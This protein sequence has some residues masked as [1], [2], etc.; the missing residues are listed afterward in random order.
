MTSSVT[1]ANVGKVYRMYATRWARLAEWLV[2]FGKP[3]HEPKWV[4]RGVDCTIAAGEAVGIV[5]VNGAGKSTLLKIIAGTT[6]PSEGVARVEGRVAALLELGIGF[7]PEFTGRQNVLMAGQLLGLSTD[8]VRAAMPAIEQFADIGDYVD[9][10]VRIYS[11][12]M[13][14][15]LAFSV[16]TAVQPDVLIVDEALAVGDAAFQRKCFRRIEE[17][18]AGGTTLLFV[19]HDTESVKKLCDRAIYL[20]QGTV[21]A[22]GPAKSVCDLYERSIFGGGAVSG[23]A[24]AATPAAPALDPSLSADCEVSYGD[25]RATI[26]A[27]WL[28]DERGNSAN[29]FGSQDTIA[30]RYRV[31]F[32]AAVSGVVFAFLIKTREGI[33]VFGTD[34]AALP[35]RSQHDFAAAEVVEVRFAMK[36]NF[37]PGTYYVN[38]GVRD[39]SGETPVFPHRRVDALVFRVRSDPA[40]AAKVGLV[41]SPTVFE[42]QPCTTSS[43]SA[44]R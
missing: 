36:N 25:Q 9:Q 42:I 19:S 23:A 40:T 18:R 29:L 7:H 43:P 20:H 16:A 11:S 2:P 13:Q 39:D 15:R 4:L 32:N 24:A 8:T 1:L 35:G 21:A 34:S 3:R 14:M 28:E 33:A 22:L 26:E 38:C 31:R 17:F 37:A 41:N 27:I 30:V 6:Q 10:P 5:G 44:P 12:G